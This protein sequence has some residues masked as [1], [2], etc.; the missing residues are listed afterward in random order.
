MTYKEAIG[1]DYFDGLDD[2]QEIE[3]A[4]QLLS[5]AKESLT[6][7]TSS[8]IHNDHIIKAEDIDEFVENGS[9]D[10]DFIFGQEKEENEGEY[11]DIDVEMAFEEVSKGKNYITFKVRQFPSFSFCL[12]V[13]VSFTPW[14]CFC[15]ILTLFCVHIHRCIYIAG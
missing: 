9:K 2:N 8:V 4:T 10:S 11:Y 5:T 13:S 3:T 12:F 15:H 14:I 1:E 7:T 6:A